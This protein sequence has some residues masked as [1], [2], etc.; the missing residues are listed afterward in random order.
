MKKNIKLCLIIATVFSLLS[1]QNVKATGEENKVKPYGMDWTT[2]KALQN[3]FKLDNNKNKLIIC[4]YSCSSDNA[5]SYSNPSTGKCGEQSNNWNAITYDADANK[6]NRWT[7][8]STIIL[9]DVE[10]Y[11]SHVI[12]KDEVKLSDPAIQ[13]YIWNGIANNLPNAYYG[14]STTGDIDELWKTDTESYKNLQQSFIC[15][16]YAFYD[17]SMDTTYYSKGDYKNQ[18]EICYADDTSSCTTRNENKTSFKHQNKLSYSLAEE[19]D[20]TLNEM[21]S[22]IDKMTNEELVKEPYGLTST[23][24]EETTEHMCTIIKNHIENENDTLSFS[25]NLEIEL[26]RLILASNRFIAQ[27]FTINNNNIATYEIFERLMN[28]EKQNASLQIMYNGTLL[29]QKYKDLKDRYVER[30]TDATMDYK[31]TCEQKYNIELNLEAADVRAEI[32]KNMDEIVPKFEN[33][34]ELSCDSIFSDIANEIKT[35][36]FFIEIIAIV[37]VIAL[38]SLE[39]AKILMSD[40]QDEFKKANKKLIRRIILLVA[41]FLL[42]AILNIILGLFKIE[43]FNSDNPLC[44]NVT[45]K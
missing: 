18:M 4:A 11:K 19:L 7:T 40:N 14:K 21:N 10:K 32:V 42:P 23:N 36:Y 26:D 8:Y 5:T 20:A 30:I 3:E 12:K 35:A 31:T 39:Y 27:Q 37:L 2:D 38:S 6:K 34:I 24:T 44:V 43:G 25:E 41:L 22:R 13:M 17:E 15:P 28:E 9:K 29:N 33:Q 1:M 16:Q 45:E